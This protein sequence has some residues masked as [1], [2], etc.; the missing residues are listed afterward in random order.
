M[1]LDN[2][3]TQTDYQVASNLASQ[4]EEYSSECNSL[5]ELI[6]ELDIQRSWFTA[7]QQ[8]STCKY[9]IEQIVPLFLY[10]HA[11]ELSVNELIDELITRS[12]TSRFGLH[13]APSQ[14]LLSCIWRRELDH[15][16]RSAI[17]NA[18]LCIR[19]IYDSD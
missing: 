1:K 19:V 18:A 5:I 2:A 16:D 14:Q 4:A 13:R 8:E 3:S 17:Q 10:K 15:S 9:P 11:R 7:Q 6:S 12:E